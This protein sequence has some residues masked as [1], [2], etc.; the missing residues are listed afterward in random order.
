MRSNY[1][2]ISTEV[3]RK[4][5]NRRLSFVHCNVPTWLTMHNTG[6]LLILQF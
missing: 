3:E 6:N 1:G 4:K 5:R 2:R